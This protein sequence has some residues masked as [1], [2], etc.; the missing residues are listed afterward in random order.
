MSTG[1]ASGVLQ[2]RRSS[3]CARVAAAAAGVPLALVSS[4]QTGLQ[5]TAQGITL[6]QPKPK[7]L[8]VL[9]V[10]PQSAAQGVECFSP[11]REAKITESPDTLFG[12][13]LVT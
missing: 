1:L 13:C 8:W 7:S 10:P 6:A 2:Q 4:F 3:A 9:I 11:S 12:F 5:A